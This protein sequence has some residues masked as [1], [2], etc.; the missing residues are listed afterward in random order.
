MKM[1]NEKSQEAEL[2]EKLKRCSGKLRKLEYQLDIQLLKGELDKSIRTKKALE[3]G[4]KHFYALSK[5]HKKLW[6]KRR[7]SSG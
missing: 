6:R 4:R 2:L 1:D 7:K 5:R 3:I